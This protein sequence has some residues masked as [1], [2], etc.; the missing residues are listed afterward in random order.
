LEDGGTFYTMNKWA[1]NGM[2][3]FDAKR[4]V[5]IQPTNISQ[6]EHA[7]YAVSP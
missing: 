7:W 2:G 5:V 6:A 3:Y 1:F 4:R